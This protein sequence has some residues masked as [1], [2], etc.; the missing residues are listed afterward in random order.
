MNI[1]HQ[2]K[3][4][5]RIKTK[6]ALIITGPEPQI[7][8]V[9]LEGRGE[10]EVAEVVAEGLFDGV[11]IFEAEGLRIVYLDNLNRALTEKE[12]DQLGQ[13][14]ILIIPANSVFSAN[15]SALE[16]K[17]TLPCLVEDAKKFCSQHQCRPAKDKVLKI[18]PSQ[19]AEENQII[20]LEAK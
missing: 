18:K 5:F 8:Q 1:S 10:Y 2:G 11:Y 13:V 15:V 12:V 6:D 16:P 3:D 19:L 4:C 9:K 17:I 7:N 14:D 20:V